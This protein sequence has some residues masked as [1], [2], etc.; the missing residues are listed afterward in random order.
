MAAFI[1]ND[2]S[3]LED[4]TMMGEDEEDPSFLAA[5][6]HAKHAF[7]VPQNPVG[8]KSKKECPGGARRNLFSMLE[9]ESTTLHALLPAPEDKETVRVYLRIKPKTLEES[10]LLSQDESSSDLVKIESCHQ[11]ALSAPKESHTCLLYTSPSP[12]D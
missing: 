11:V 4:T 3:L 2:D 8:A 5:A 7:A 12:R 9:S 10:A 6:A 1:I